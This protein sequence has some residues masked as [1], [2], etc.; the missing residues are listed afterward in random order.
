[1]PTDEPAPNG[2][3]TVQLVDASGSPVSGRNI[4][5]TGEGLGLRSGDTNSQGEF[6][7]SLTGNQ[8][9]D[10]ETPDGWPNRSFELPSGG[11][12]YRTIQASGSSSGDDS[13]SSGS[14]GGNGSGSTGD[15]TGDNFEGDLPGPDEFDGTMVAILAVAA[16]GA[17]VVLGGGGS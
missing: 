15:D 14:D 6:S 2:T 8:T 4:R 13:G 7:A 3:I 10:V 11:S 17:Y 5:V 12:I 9:V 1:M 16:V